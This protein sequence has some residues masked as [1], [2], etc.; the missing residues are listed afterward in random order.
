MGRPFR[1]AGAL[2]TLQRPPTAQVVAGINHYLTLET[3]DDA[4]KKTVEVTVWEKLPS[5]VKGNELPIELTNFKI[6]SGNGHVSSR[7][8]VGTLP[9]VALPCAASHWPTTGSRCWH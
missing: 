1:A 6:L 9:V 3:Q 4:G 2:L 8:P 7:R 5:N